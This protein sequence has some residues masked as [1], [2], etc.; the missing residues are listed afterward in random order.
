MN[1]GIL[2]TLKFIQSIK[3]E[4]TV[5]RLIVFLMMSMGLVSCQSQNQN[6]VELKSK[7][8]SV[9]YSIGVNIGKDLKSNGLEINAEILGIALSKAYS[10]DSIQ[11]SDEEMMKIMM[12]FQQEMMNAQNEKSKG[13]SES[14][15][16]EGEAFLAENKNK[17]GVK[18]TPSGLQY[19]VLKSASGASPKETDQVKTHYLGKLINGTE[20][21]N[22]Y[23]RGEPAV[24]PLNGVIKGWTEALQL[25]KVG[26]KFELY[27]PAELA[28]GDQGAG[29]IIPPGAT[30]IFEVELLEIVK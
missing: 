16:K 18:T 24:F 25:M 10:G 7:Q 27:I 22:S 20:F 15:R 1:F 26:E 30:L 14:A 29:Q 19:K 4:I 5:K 28:Y 9:S 6:P 23:K 12:S 8:D 2:T 11:L 3:K 21:D 13:L 17:P